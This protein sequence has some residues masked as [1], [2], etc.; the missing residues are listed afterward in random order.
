LGLFVL[1]PLYAKLSAIM[2]T[3][4]LKQL[5]SLWL[6]PS[7]FYSQVVLQE[8]EGESSRFSVLTALFVA[9][10]LGLVEA[11]SDRSI[12]IVALV[13]V[14]LLVAMPFLVTVWTYLWSG[15]IKLCAGLLGESLPWEPLR[16]VV[17]YSAAGLTAL[18]LGYGLGKWVALA[19]F[20]FQVIGIEKAIR[21]SRWTAIVY[22]GLPFSMVAVLGGFFAFMFKVFK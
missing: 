6:Q 14:I 3:A 16:R 4:Y 7:D 21:C 12:W 5:R 1:K 17:A 2:I 15:F 18:G 9:L 20:L 13:T 22:V 8:G 10:E 19:T 11:F